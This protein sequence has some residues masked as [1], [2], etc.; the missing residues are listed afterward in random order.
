MFNR[1]ILHSYGVP[2]C[3]G[4]NLFST[5]ISLLR[6][7]ETEV[8]TPLGVSHSDGYATIFIEKNTP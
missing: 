5:N 4:Y 6:R 3:F 8:R 1:K 7:E 2:L